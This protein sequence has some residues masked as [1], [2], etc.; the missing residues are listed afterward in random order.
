MEF[1]SSHD[2][3]QEKRKE[4]I[5]RDWLGY[6]HNWSRFRIIQ[7]SNVLLM[8]AVSASHV[9]LMDFIKE[10][11]ADVSQSRTFA[12]HLQIIDDLT[13]QYHPKC[14]ETRNTLQKLATLGAVTQKDIDAAFD[15][16]DNDLPNFALKIR[17]QFEK[18]NSQVYT[19]VFQAFGDNVRSSGN[20]L[21]DAVAPE[22]LLSL[23]ATV[24]RIIKLC[25]LR[26]KKPNDAR[27][28]FVID[29]LRHPFE[30]RFLRERFAPFYVMAVTTNDADRKLRLGTKLLPDE[31]VELDR[32]EYPSETG[33][34]RDTYRDLVSQDI[35]ACLELADVYISN[36]GTSKSVDTRKTAQQVLRYVALMQ[37]PGLVTP[38]HIERCMQTAFSAKLN[39]GCISRQV[40]ASVTDKN[41]SIKAIGWNDVPQGQVPCLLRNTY[42]L[43]EGT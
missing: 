30:I 19:K 37:R 13:A 22:A 31:I 43:L 23:P 21:S 36:P 14:L 9:E 35:Q 27:D 17:D 8:I 4:R 24:A 42:H 32:K 6:E 25:R 39:S 20:P 12:A 2:T 15:F 34:S 7:V 5:I 29:A 11:L 28:Y 26:S 40:G 16:F 33:Q 1:N 41:Y 10:K 38:S 18:I 3:D